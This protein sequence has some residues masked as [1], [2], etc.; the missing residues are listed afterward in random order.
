MIKYLE[1]A[2][3]Y[4]WLLNIFYPARIRVFIDGLKSFIIE[5]IIEFSSGEERLATLEYEKL[6]TIVF[7]F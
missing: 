5:I 6:E 7:F 3:D 4:G 1:W 2:C